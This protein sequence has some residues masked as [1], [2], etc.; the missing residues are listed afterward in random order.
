M[1]SILIERELT[2]CRTHQ[3]QSCRSRQAGSEYRARDQGSC[4]YRSR[5]YRERASLTITFTNI[6][7]VRSQFPNVDEPFLPLK[8]FA[9]KGTL[10]PT[11]DGVIKP[12]YRVP[13][14]RV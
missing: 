6:Q 4:E 2:L 13:D 12:K 9:S 10:P 11:N 5:R 3:E 8:V 7:G 1:R 14:G